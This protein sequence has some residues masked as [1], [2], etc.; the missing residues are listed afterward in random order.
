MKIFLKV[1]FL[2]VILFGINPLYAQKDKESEPQQSA[3]EDFLLIQGIVVDGES[4]L[5]GVTIRLYKGNTK[6]DSVYTGKNGTFKFTLGGD[7]YY[8]MEYSRVGYENTCVLI[9]T[10]RWDVAPQDEDNGYQ[11]DFEVEL[12][13]EISNKNA[14]SLSAVDL[15]VLDFPKVL[16]GYKAGEEEGFFSDKKY[17]KEVK[18][19]LKKVKLSAK[20]K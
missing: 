19:S 3:S 4:R 2:F 7:Y 11:V 15:D 12:I 9:N 13:P 17:T 14:L 16:I 10:N 1:F 18:E 8:A 5:E 6:I 20:K